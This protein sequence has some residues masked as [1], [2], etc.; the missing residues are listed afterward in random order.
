MNKKLHYCLIGGI[1]I[2]QLV[3]ILLLF[4]NI[5]S[6]KISR[7]NCNIDFTSCEILLD[8]IYYSAYSYN[9]EN[10][11]YLVIITTITLGISTTTLISSI[12]FKNRN[13]NF[14]T[15]GLSLMTICLI[16]SMFIIAKVGPQKMA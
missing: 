8:T 5:Y 3:L 16:V 12:I 4:L 11:L 13:Y 9:V 6:Y 15:Y 1:F 2:A 10:F 7:E 14:V